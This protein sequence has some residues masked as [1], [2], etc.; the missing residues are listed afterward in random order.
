MKVNRFSTP[1]T[2]YAGVLKLDTCPA[3]AIENVL[4]IVALHVVKQCIIA[5]DHRA[6]ITDINMCVVSFDVE[7][8]AIY[9]KN[10]G[11]YYVEKTG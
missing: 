6:V 8:A 2:A 5:K 9:D 7:F 1:I 10:S 3:C 11:I 4:C